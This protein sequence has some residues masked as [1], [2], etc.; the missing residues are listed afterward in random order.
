MRFGGIVP[1]LIAIPTIVLASEL[2]FRHAISAEV[3]AGTAAFMAFCCIAAVWTR[4]Q[5][6]TAWA[7]VWNQS[8]LSVALVLASVLLSGPEPASNDIATVFDAMFLPDHGI[9]G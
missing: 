9:D 7:K 1:M 3:A 5:G 8:A 6:N 4:A 2:Y